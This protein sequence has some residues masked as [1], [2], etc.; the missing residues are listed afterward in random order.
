M[1]ISEFVRFHPILNNDKELEEIYQVVS[2]GKTVSIDL[3]SPP[4]YIWNNLTS[5]NRNVIRKA[6]KK[7]VLKYTGDVMLI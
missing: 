2:L 6:R 3:K 7:M 5:K 4:E 1:D